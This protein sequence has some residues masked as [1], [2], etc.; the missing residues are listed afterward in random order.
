MP[1][2]REFAELLFVPLFYVLVVFC[3]LAAVG[4]LSRDS[5]L[6]RWRYAF[7]LAAVITYAV[8]TPFFP[9]LLLRNI[10][11][12]YKKPHIPAA[13]VHG[14]SL[15]IVLSAGWPRVTKHGWDPKIGE[16]G[17]ESTYAAVL[18]W[19]RVGGT[20]RFV[21]SPTPDNVDSAANEM[22]LVAEHLGV[23]SAHIEIERDSL[24]THQN[25]QFSSRE[26]RRHQGPVWLVT[27]ASHMPRAMAVAH[28]LGLSIIPYPCFYRA[29]GRVTVYSWLPSNKSPLILEKVLHEWVGLLYYRLRGWA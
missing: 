28:R 8:S 2:I 11:S 13:V 16:S 12:T 19:D 25:I 1:S 9:N 22:A 26:I 20:L 6:R 10:E 4:F 3:G 18:L 23:P 21:G 29:D 5:L 7:I 27:T 14:K 24:D 17:W 15:I